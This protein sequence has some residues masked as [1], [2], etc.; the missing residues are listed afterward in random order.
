[1]WSTWLLV[2]FA[3]LLAVAAWLV[4]VWAIRSGQYDNVEDVKYRILED[5]DDDASPST[6][7]R[8]A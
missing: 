3:L 1:M 2:A 4:L 8:E 5:D 7:K 6:P